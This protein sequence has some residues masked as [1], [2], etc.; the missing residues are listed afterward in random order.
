M[1]KS[2]Y[3]LRQVCLSISM[4]RLGSK[5]TE[6]HEIWNKIIFRKSVTKIQFW[7]KYSKNIG[8]FTWCTFITISC[9]IFLRM[10]NVSGRKC[11][12]NQNTFYTQYIFSE[13]RTVHKTM[14]KK[15]GRPKQATDNNILRR[16]LR[17][18]NTYCYITAK[19][20]TRTRL[21]VT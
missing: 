9:W 12:E 19:T 1:T 16:M 7:L 20:V 10:R 8:C 17:I 18:F 13:N 21:H 4:E 14:W 11:T 15:Y 5:S 2:D 3:S 6:F